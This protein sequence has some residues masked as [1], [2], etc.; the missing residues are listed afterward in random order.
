MSIEGVNEEMLS[1]KAGMVQS[2][3]NHRPLSTRTTQ[4]A[5]PPF[6]GRKKGEFVSPQGKSVGRDG[7]VFAKVESAAEGA[8]ALVSG[9]SVLAGKIAVR[10]RPPPFAYPGRKA[11]AVRHVVAIIFF[12]FGILHLWA[13]LADERASG[14]KKRAG[15]IPTPPMNRT[16]HLL[17]A[18]M[19]LSMGA[20]L[21][22]ARVD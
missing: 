11:R 22:F 8:L 21:W 13:A 18:V 7:R 3:R 20:V 9:Q 19:L 15:R 2:S 5:A 1:F 6:P 12:A 16:I 4:R 17:A 10:R 14:V